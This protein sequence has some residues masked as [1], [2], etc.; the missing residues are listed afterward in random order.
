MFLTPVDAGFEGYIREVF[1]TWCAGVFFMETVSSD[2]LKFKH[3]NFI[4][5]HYIMS[6][7]I[8][9]LD[10]RK[11]I[12]KLFDNINFLCPILCGTFSFLVCPKRITHMDGYSETV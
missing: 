9:R 10:W 6:V 8:V 4:L 2:R 1:L 3:I 11:R 12:R 7:T 5:Q